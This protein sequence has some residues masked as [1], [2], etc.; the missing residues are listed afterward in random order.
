M[1]DISFVVN[2]EL[3]DDGL[4]HAMRIQ[5]EMPIDAD[6]QTYLAEKLTE[7]PEDARG[8]VSE[9]WEASGLMWLNN[10]LRQVS[11]NG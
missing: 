5:D 7:I 6:P 8:L 9:L 2:N 11:T 1:P 10:S 4:E 3:T